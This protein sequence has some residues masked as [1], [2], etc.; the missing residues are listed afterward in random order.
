VQKDDNL[1]YEWFEKSA[2]QGHAR[3]RQLIEKAA[4]QGNVY[5]AN[6]LKKLQEQAAAAQAQADAQAQAQAQADTQ[7]QADKSQ[8]L[9]QEDASPAEDTSLYKDPTF[10]SRGKKGYGFSADI[11]SNRT[12]EPLQYSVAGNAYSKTDTVDYTQSGISAWRCF[13]DTSVIASFRRGSG[14]INTATNAGS[15][16]KSFQTKDIEIEGRWIIRKL[17]SSSVLPYVLAGYAQKSKNGVADELQ[18]RDIYTQTD[19]VL[20]VGGGAIFLLNNEAGIRLEARAGADS[21]KLTGNNLAGSYNNTNTS[22]YSSLG[23]TLFYDLIFGW[24]AQFGARY[25]KYSGGA[26]STNT[27]FSAKLGYAYK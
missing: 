13:D 6:E 8:T 25:E 19:R 27:S 16:N 18:F 14:N 9:Q 3:S 17:S 21:Q 12:T 26:A 15:V 2:A 22:A 1:A 10:A 4:T 23:A 7:A 20:L 24:N 11:S 5:A